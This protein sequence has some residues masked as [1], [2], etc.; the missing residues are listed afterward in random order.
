LELVDE[1]ALVRRLFQAINAN[2][3]EAAAGV[4]SP[5]HVFTDGFSRILGHGASGVHSLVYDR[6]LKVPDLRYE[7][8]ELICEP[9]VVAATWV[10]SGTPLGGSSEVHVRG[11]SRHRIRNGRIAESLLTFNPLGVLPKMRL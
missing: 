9:G 1:K 11:M 5:N 4:L 2:D 7:V 3:K 8:E 6:Q 10:A